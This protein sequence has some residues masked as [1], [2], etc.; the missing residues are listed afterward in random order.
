[1]L[2][3]WSDHRLSAAIA[4]TDVL[5]PNEAEALGS[6]GAATL[7]DA[8]GPDDAASLDAAASTLAAAG[9]RLVVKLG[10][11]GA[12][13]ADGTA[14]HLVSVDPV[15]PADTTGAGDCFKTPA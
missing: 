5:L 2:R 10:E 13:C 1:M 15:T 7:N 9:R 11:R 6:A 14:R 3:G 4:Q 8:V 12:L